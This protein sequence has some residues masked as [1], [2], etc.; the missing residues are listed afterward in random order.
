MGFYPP[1]S[2]VRDAQRRGVEVL[3]PDV[4]RSAAK[5]R[6]QNGAVRVGLGYVKGLG[7]APAVALVEEREAGGAFGSV[8]DLARRAPL[9]RPALEALVA[10][11]ACDSFGWPRRQ[12]LWRLGLAPRSVSA[13]AGGAERQLALPLE[14]TSEIPELAEQTPWERML[15]DYRLTSLS[16]GLHPLEL[17]RPHLPGEVLSS[18]E[19]E[20]APHGARVA[21]AGLAVARQRPATASGVV[22]MLIED[23]H[24]QMNLIVPPPVYDRYRALVRGEPLLLARG[25]FERVDRNRNVLVVGARLARAARAPRRG[26]RRGARR[27]AGRPPL[28]RSLRS[29]LPPVPAR[30]LWLQEALAAED[31]VASKQ[32]VE[33]MRADVCIVGGGYT[34]LWTALRLAELEPG[35]SIALVEADICGGGPSGRNGGFAL[36]WWPKVETLVKR[37]GEEEAFRLVRASAAGGRRAR[38]LLRA[39]GHR[40]ALP[41]RRLALDG[42]L[43]GPARLVGRRGR[44][45]GSR[46]RAAVR[47]PV[48]R[49]GA[50][51]DRLTGPPRRR[52]RGAAPRPCSPRCSPAAFAASP[53]SE[54]CRSSSARRCWS[55]TVTAASSARR[56]A[57]SRLAR[58]CWRRAP[59]WRR[60][61][62][63]SARSSRSPATWSP[64]RPCPS[65]SR[66]PAGPAAS[67]S[68]TAA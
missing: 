2:L 67:R 16:V 29:L 14:P 11:G 28:R 56:P 6:L 40:R 22:F 55:S 37:V 64:P 34:G 39:R 32:L 3:P 53:W 8:A 51:A 9:D 20:E 48:R 30:S 18:A 12:L 47:A 41:S 25:R 38:R 60:S 42:H 27:H 58:S 26:R 46:R 31:G 24:G 4:N 36:S 21:V 57:P 52:L 59:G 66:R 44:G 15:A 1:A 63:S 45:G 13:G 19:L 35:A 7:E 54:A 61:P 43:A 10:S 49:G 33:P 65:G 68:P 62:S 23:E 17:L 5:C 50:A